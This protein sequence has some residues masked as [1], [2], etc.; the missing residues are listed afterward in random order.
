M[1]SLHFNYLYLH[2]L[3]HENLTYLEYDAWQSSRKKTQ[4]HSLT[5]LLCH[6]LEHEIINLV[7][8]FI[9][10]KAPF[11]PKKPAD[12]SP[13]MRSNEIVDKSLNI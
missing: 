5:S 7:Y 4:I 2:F 3:T 11:I 8:L 13:D 12:F 1:F 10:Y 6:A 9:C